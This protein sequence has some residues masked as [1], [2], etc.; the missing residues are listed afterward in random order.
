METFMKEDVF[1]DKLENKASIIQPGDGAR[2]HAGEGSCTFKVTSDMSSGRLGV[3]EIVI[4]PHTMGARLHYHRFM[5]EVFIVNKGIL[6]VDLGHE[7]HQLASGATVY[8]PRFTPH[9]FSNSVDEVLVITLIFNPSEHRE[10]YFKG[11]FDLLDAEA[12]DIPR[13]LQLAQKYDTHPLNTQPH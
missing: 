11:L 10:G 8:V 3:Y 1:T 9:G 7:T 2:V 5:D 13:F 6:T 12:M 4:P